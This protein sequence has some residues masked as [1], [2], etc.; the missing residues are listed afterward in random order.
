MSKLPNG[1]TLS[2]VDFDLDEYYRLN[3][4]TSIVQNSRI[5]LLCAIFVFICTTVLL[6]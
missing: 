1:Y 2:K 5:L 6:W 3:R 4:F